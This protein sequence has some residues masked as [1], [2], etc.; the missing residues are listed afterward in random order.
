MQRRDRP[1]NVSG[2]RHRTTG[3]AFDIDVNQKALRAGKVVIVTEQADLVANAAVSLM[4][5]PHS[6]IDDRWKGDLLEVP[7]TG[8]CDEADDRTCPDIE[9]T[10]F[11]QVL[12]DGGIEERK[13]GDVCHV[14]VSVVVAPSR[15]HRAK[16]RESGSHLRSGSIAHR[17]PMDFWQRLIPPWLTNRA[18]FNINLRNHPREMADNDATSRGDDRCFRIKINPSSPADK[19]C[20]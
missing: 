14:T 16:V 8:F 9:D 1:A 4:T 10:P 12:T 2:Y 19:R 20:P 15:R 3:L 13:I 6:D 18:C 17:N 11:N 5:N 7:A